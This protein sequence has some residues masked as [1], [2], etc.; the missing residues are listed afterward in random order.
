MVGE[1]PQG[2]SKLCYQRNKHIEGIGLLWLLVTDR[3]ASECFS[4]SKMPARE[5]DEAR[6]EVAVL[7]QMKHPNI[8]SYIDSFEG[9]ALLGLPRHS[10]FC[11]PV[12]FYPRAWQLVY[13]HGLL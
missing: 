8:V 5:R 9:R 11:I 3:F 10:S 2:P 13:S 1:K 4:C 12:L 7:A 6:K